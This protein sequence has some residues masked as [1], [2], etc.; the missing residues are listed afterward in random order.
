MASQNLDEFILKLTFKKP[1]LL[2]NVIAYFTTI[3]NAITFKLYLLST[4][5]LV[6]ETAKFHFFREK[7]ENHKRKTKVFKIAKNQAK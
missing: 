2:E 4:P 6:T 5:L 3:N 1:K 7:T